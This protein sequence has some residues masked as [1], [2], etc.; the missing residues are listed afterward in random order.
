MIKRLLIK[1]WANIFVEV[2]GALGGGSLGGA[3]AEPL[4]DVLSDLAGA[5][6]IVW[7]KTD[8]RDLSVAAT[9][10]FFRDGREVNAGIEG[11]PGI[12][13]DGN[14]GANRRSADANRK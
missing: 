6:Q 2:G 5:R 12:A 1:S 3:A 4:S 9:A 13:A 7:V 11:L 10:V 8:G 14:F